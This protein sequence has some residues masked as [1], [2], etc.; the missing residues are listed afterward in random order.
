MLAR[1]RGSY[2][3]SSCTMCEY[4]LRRSLVGALELGV[5]S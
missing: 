4:A 5:T 3:T 1:V 2:G